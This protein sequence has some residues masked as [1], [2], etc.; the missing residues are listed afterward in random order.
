M[1]AAVIN[2]KNK[3]PRPH[4]ESGTLS[5]KLSNSEVRE[6]L[7][8]AYAENDI[9]NLIEFLAYAKVFH[10]FIKEGRK[11]FRKIEEGWAKCQKEHPHLGNKFNYLTGIYSSDPISRTDG[12]QIANRSAIIAEFSNKY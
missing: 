5:P 3:L 12:I 8:K 4:F 7:E 9:A 1:P 6:K 2:F 11:F 10:L